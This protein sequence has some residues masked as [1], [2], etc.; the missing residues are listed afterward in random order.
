VPFYL[1]YLGV[2]SYGLIGFL[3]FTQ[4]VVVALLDFGLGPTISREVARGSA[5]GDLQAASEL[6]RTLATIY[7]TT[8]AAIFTVFLLA[9]PLIAGR[10]LSTDQLSVETVASAAAFIGLVIACRWPLG[11][12]QSVLVGAQRLA[13]SSAINIAIVTVANVGG[14]AILAFVSATAQALFAWQGFVALIGSFAMM[15]AAWRSIGP[16]QRVPFSWDRLRRVWRFSAGVSVVAMTSI[17]LLQLDK[18]VLSS[19]LSLEQFGRY[20]LAVLVANSLYV[21]LRPLF[22]TIYPKM[23][24]LVVSGSVDQLSEFYRTGT[25]LLASILFPIAAAVSVSSNDLVYVWTR[26][27]TMAQSVGPLVS[28]L[29]W[30]TALNGIMYF[31]YALQ[32]AFGRPRL[33]LT[34]NVSL[35]AIYAPLA[36]ALTSVHGVVGG[37]AAWATI[38][39]IYLFLGTWLTHRHLLRGIAARWLTSNVFV[40][41][42]ISALV[43][44]ASTWLV[45]ETPD[46]AVLRIVIAAIAAGVAVF[47]NVAADRA[48]VRRLMDVW[49]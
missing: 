32:L 48:A 45:R 37:A 34:V 5:Q 42:V 40:P 31:P 29:V 1:R 15:R 36:V 11:L 38:N 43:I 20:M 16:T 6:L 2:E 25:R 21:L 44:G 14:V 26:D 17:A 7:W 8:A 33:A 49:T 39:V 35:I 3:T 22:N 4:S 46:S 12:Y 19:L 47:A 28:L 13:T 41:L 30:G 27:A 18:G 9:A 10:W 24:A 23:S